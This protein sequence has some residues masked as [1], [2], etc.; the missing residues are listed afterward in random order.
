MA[1]LTSRNTPQRDRI[2]TVA[3]APYVARVAAPRTHPAC[4]YTEKIVNSIGLSRH[5]RAHAPLRR[6]RRRAGRP[7][8]AALRVLLL[9]AATFA[10]ACERPDGPDSPPPLGADAARPVAADPRLAALEERFRPG[11]HALMVDLQFRHA[12]LWFAGEAENWRLADYHMHEIEEL[13][14]D[15][16]ELHPTYDGIPVADLLNALLMP[17]VEQLA[18][19]VDDGDGPAFEMAFDRFT[20]QCNA[21]HQASDRA[22]IVVQRPRTPPFDNVRYAPG[23]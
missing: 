2:D 17:T 10:V 20:A 8:V 3:N 22:M 1:L 9:A 16:L 12:N 6:A 13:T 7:Q 18:A 14:G 4:R 15:I 11:L 19:V 21:C 5:G 23:Q